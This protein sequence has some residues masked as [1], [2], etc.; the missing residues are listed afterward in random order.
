MAPHPA[1]KAAGNG[2]SLLRR[3]HDKA[4]VAQCCYPGSFRLDFGSHEIVSDH[5]GKKLVCIDEPLSSLQTRSEVGASDH[6]FQRIQVRK[7][8]A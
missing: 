4:S 2:R 6:A 3:R 5:T 8:D 7:L 1:S